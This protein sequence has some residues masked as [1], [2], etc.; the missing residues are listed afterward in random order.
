MDKYYLMVDIIRRLLM[1]MHCI[2][3]IVGLICLAG[4]LDKVTSASINSTTSLPVVG[5]LSPSSRTQRTVLWSA[6]YVS[7]SWLDCSCSWLCL[8]HSNAFQKSLL[9]ESSATCHCNGS[10]SRPTKSILM[11]P[12]GSNSGRKWMLTW[13][14]DTEVNLFLLILSENVCFPF[15]NN[16]RNDWNAFER[17]VEHDMLSFDDYSYWL[18]ANNFWI[19]AWM[20]DT[21]CVTT[22]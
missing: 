2:Q 20:L 6:C 12:Q 11:L 5:L 22:F 21:S 15:R 14:P 19:L 7:S 18:K 4:T 16:S 10:I 3:S 17:S 13:K 8:L 9:G 1:K